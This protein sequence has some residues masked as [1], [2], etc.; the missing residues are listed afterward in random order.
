MPYSA[1]SKL[2]AFNRN[3]IPGGFKRLSLLFFSA[4]TD[5]LVPYSIRDSRS[6]SDNG[7]LLFTAAA[8]GFETAPKGGKKK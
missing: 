1:S 8:V 5:T 6:E 7:S 2:R 4:G 3:F